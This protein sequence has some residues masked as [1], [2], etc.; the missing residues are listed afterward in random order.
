MPRNEATKLLDPKRSAEATKLL[1]PKEAAKRTAAD[2][3]VLGRGIV[4][5]TDDRGYATPQNRDPSRIVLDVREGYIRLW[6]RRTTLRWRFQEQSMQVFVDPEAA[7]EYIRGLMSDAVTAWGDSVPVQ[8]N[9]T[10]DLWDFEV[11]MVP[12]DCDDNGCVL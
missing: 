5:K 3:H 6:A 11:A 10:P 1:D 9:E 2:L 4:C 8:F 12:D 7:K